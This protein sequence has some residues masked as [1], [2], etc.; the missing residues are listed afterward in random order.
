MCHVAT[1]QPGN[2]HG[3]GHGNGNG[4]GNCGN[5]PCGG[6][7]VPIETDWLLYLGVVAGGYFAVKKSHPAKKR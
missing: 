3:N 7:Q 1:A 5:P 6:P 2:G 4:S